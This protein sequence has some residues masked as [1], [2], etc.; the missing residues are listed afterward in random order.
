ML[1]QFM[2]VCLV[3]DAQYVLLSAVVFIQFFSILILFLLLSWALEDHSF[4]WDNERHMHPN[5]IYSFTQM[6]CSSCATLQ[7]FFIAQLL[8]DEHFLFMANLGARLHV[9]DGVKKVLRLILRLYPLRSEVKLKICVVLSRFDAENTATDGLQRIPIR[10]GSIAVKLAGVLVG[11][12][13]S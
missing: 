12:I 11:F 2:V 8:P 7:L 13:R 10:Q 5:S 4:A 1:S 3:E 9:F 6:S